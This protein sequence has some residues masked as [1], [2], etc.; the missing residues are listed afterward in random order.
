[1]AIGAL[2]AS[3]RRIPLERGNR[4]RSL[5]RAKLRIIRELT[6]ARRGPQPNRTRMTLR[7]ATA[8]PR[9]MG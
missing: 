6:A 2:L 3:V 1:M 4:G 5:E 7:S 8:I 9:L